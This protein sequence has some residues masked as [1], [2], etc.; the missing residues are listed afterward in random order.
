MILALTWQVLI[1]DMAISVPVYLDAR[2]ARIILVC[3]FDYLHLNQL[4]KWIETTDRG[5]YENRWTWLPI[6]PPSGGRQGGQVGGGQGRGRTRDNGSTLASDDDVI[7]VDDI[8]VLDKTCES[9]SWP[10]YGFQELYD[11]SEKGDSIL[12]DMMTAPTG[13]K[14][15]LRFYPKGH[16][17]S[18]GTYA[19][20]FLHLHKDSN[21]IEKSVPSFQ[22]CFWNCHSSL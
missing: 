12:S 8:S 9:H 16:P 11:K 3:K 10:I 7:V 17:D 5:H 14:F 20:L 6:W 22:K 13:H 19:S 1:L 18:D 4:S 15:K 21:D 2:T